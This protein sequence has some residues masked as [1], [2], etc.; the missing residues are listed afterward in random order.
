MT[1][2]NLLESAEGKDT[3]GQKKLGGKALFVPLAVLL[4]VFL[5]F[6]GAKF[7]L[8]SLDKEKNQI[9]GEIKLESA[10]LN[11]KNVDRVADFQERMKKAA[12]ESSSKEN[13]E[14]Y[15]EE[16]ETLVVSGARVES[17][18]YSPEE[19]A[20]AMT[21]DNFKTMARQ[22]LSLKQ[23][24]FFRDLKTGGASRKE[25]GKISFTLGK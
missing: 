19:I 9:D 14:S 16:M 22:V 20:I 2:I 17:L 3:Q 15:L 6:G 13:Y 7:Y 12:G 18:Q 21:A 4:A 8:S 10:N 11:G 25:D 24:K 5:A 23:S 1:N